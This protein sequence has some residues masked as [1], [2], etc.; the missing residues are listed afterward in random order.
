[1]QLTVEKNS[2]SRFGGEWTKEKLEMLR[3]YLDAYTTALKNQSFK[4]VYID[5]FAGS[6][7]VEIG[8]DS[9]HG[10]IDGSPRIAI[11]IKERRFDRLIFNEKNSR[12]YDNLRNDL[13]QDTRCTFEKM[14]ANEFIEKLRMDW[15]EWRGVLFMDPFGTEVD[16]STIERIAELNALDTWILHPKSALERMLP[17]H[18]E[19]EVP[20]WDKKLDKIFG[21]GEWRNLYYDQPTVFTGEYQKIRHPAKKISNLYK[22]N[23]KK[24]FGNRFLNER[25]QFKNKNNV[26][27]FEFIF[28]AG[29][30]NGSAIAKR[31]A[32]YIIGAHQKNNTI[33]NSEEKKSIDRYLK[34]RPLDEY[35]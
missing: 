15:I 14:D 11:R 12:Q 31:I 35:M 32:G 10:Y 18:N 5:A 7:R 17:K 1:M 4:L 24:L 23:L 13:G 22:N 30:P 26:V 6:G 25:F 8:Q 33:S 21:N 2:P 28:C 27:M 20:G 19:P 29:N 3:Q 16:W 34:N 9:F